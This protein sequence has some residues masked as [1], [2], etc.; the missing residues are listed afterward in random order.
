[1]RGRSEQGH[2]LA[3]C[4]PIETG[5]TFTQRGDVTLS[6][7]GVSVLDGLVFEAGS[8]HQFDPT[9]SGSGTEIYQVRWEQT[10]YQYL[11]VAYNGSV[12]SHVT[13]EVLGSGTAAAYN[14]IGSATALATGL[15]HATYTDFANIGTSSV[16]G[17]RVRA[18]GTQTLNFENCTFS[19]CGAIWCDG[20]ISADFTVKINDS[21]FSDGVDASSL[22]L[23]LRANTT[24]TAGSRECLRSVFGGLVQCHDV[25]DFDFTNCVFKNNLLH[26]GTYEPV[27][28]SECLIIEPDT[29]AG[30]TNIRGD[31]TDSYFVQSNEGSNPHGWSQIGTTIK[32]VVWE[33]L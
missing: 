9:A 3:D 12:G 29:N 7:S 23:Y 2:S 13:V 1:M 31:I 28:V 19:Q 25:R 33:C 30:G 16:Y 20:D 15:V 27:T 18:S 24:Q 26:T 5:D 11:F 8:T 21:T 32:D 6:G 22:D 14:S 10:A 17:W 4:G